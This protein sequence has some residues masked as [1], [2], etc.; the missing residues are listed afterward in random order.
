[1]DGKVG[2]NQKTSGPI[3]RID[4]N[5]LHADDPNYFDDLYRST[6]RKGDKYGL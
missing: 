4:P 2:P 1:M 6:T 3:A 5:E